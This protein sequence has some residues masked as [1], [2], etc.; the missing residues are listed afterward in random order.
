MFYLVRTIR[1]K[2]WH[3]R[4]TNPISGTGSVS[5]NILQS[6]KSEFD[7]SVSDECR[8]KSISIQT[9]NSVTIQQYL[10]MIFLI[11]SYREMRSHV[12][13]LCVRSKRYCT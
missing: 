9:E 12:K 10:V 13:G 11:H 2:Y 3:T 1:G 4:V 8:V 6:V 7:F 5:F